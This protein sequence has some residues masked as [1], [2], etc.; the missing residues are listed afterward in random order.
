MVTPEEAQRLSAINQQSAN[1]PGSVLVQATK[2]QADNSFVDSLTDFFS[3]AKEKTYGAL[4]NAVFEQFNVNPDTGGFSELA[5]K[6]GLLGVRALYENVV[7][8]PIRTIGLVQQ[9]STWSEAYKKAQIEPF[10]YW[11]EAK[12]KGQKVDLGNALFQST[13]P[14]KTQTY[15]DLIDKGADPIKAR[16]IAISRLGVNVFDKVFEQEK[17]AQFDGDRAAALIARGKSPHMTPGRVLFKP[18]EFIAGPEDRAYDFYTGLIDLGLNLLDPTFWAGKAVKTVKAGRSMLTLTDEGADTFGLFKNGFVRKS[19][20]KT[21]AEQFLNSKQGDILAKFLYDN[22]DKP[23]EIL[24]KSNFKLVNQFVI[25]DQALSDEF[26]KFT[27]SLFSLPDNLPEQEAIA[28]IKNIWNE[29]IL[30]TATS[31]VVPVAPGMS[32]TARVAPDFLV[33]KVGTVRRAIDDYFGP[34]YETKLSANN[35]DK[36]I[37]EYTKFLKLLDPKDQLANRSQRVKNLITEITKKEVSNPAIRGKFIINQVMEDFSDLQKLYVK[38]LEDT[39]KLTT[40]TKELIRNVFST[41]GGILEEQSQL[42][43]F[44]PVLNNFKG[45]EDQISYLFKK[46]DL[47]K[48][49]TESQLDELGTNFGSRPVLE[50]M[51][52]QDLKLQNPSKVIKLTKTLDS[53]FNGNFQEA[54]RIIG[55]EGINRFFDFY[56][57]QIFKPIVLLRPAW[58]VRVIIEEQLRAVANGALGV[59]DHPIGLLARIFDDNIKVRGSYAKEGWLDTANFKLGISE[60]ASGQIGK[61]V[62]QNQKIKLSNQLKFDEA[63]RTQKPKEWADGQ[64]R[65]INLLRTD[66]ISKKIAAIEL[67]DNPSKG[68]AELAKALKTPGNQYREA[69]INLT[70]GRTNILKVLDGTAGLTPKEYDDAI[71]WFILGMRNN[72]K[73]FLSTDGKTVNPDLYNIVIKGT[74]TNAKG[75]TLSLDTARNIGVKQTDLDLLGKNALDKKQSIDIQRKATEY[76]KKVLKEYIDKFGGVLPEKVDYKVPDLDVPAGFYDIFVEKAFQFFMTTPTNKMSRIP[77]F[78][79]SYWKKSEELISISSENV[80]QK[81]IAGANKAGLNKK[82]I[83]RMEDTTS[84]GIK[85]IDDP[86]LIEVMAKG[87]GVEQTKKLLYDITQQRRFWEASRW[88]FPF[89]NAYQEVLTTWVGIMK[90]NPNVI[91]RTGT[92]WDGA[93][94]ENDTF[95]PSGKGIF[96]KNPINGQVVF[97]YPGTG[98]LQDWMFKDSA[99]NTDVRINMPVYAESINIA[100]GLLPGFGPVI[101]IPAAFIFKNFPEE[102]FVN[103]VLFGEFPP[104]DVNNKDEWTKALGL[105]PAWAD[106]FIQLIFNKGENAQGAFGNTVIDVYK[107]LLYSGQIDD[108]TEEKAKIGMQKAVETAQQVFLF[109]AVSQFLGPA[110]AASPIFEITDKNANYFMFETLADEYRKIKESVNYDDALA[111]Q[112]FIE[113]FGINPLPLT[114]AK[115]VTIEKRPT[116]VDGADWMKKNMDLYDQY[117]LV[118]W[119]LEPP[120]SYAEFSFDAYRKSLLEGTREYRTPEQFQ[121]AKNKLLGSVALEQYERE[122]G[123]IGNNTAAAKALRDAKKK[124]LEQRYWGYGQPGIAGSPV[125]PSI[126]TQIDQLIKMTQDPELQNFATIQAAQ[127]Y[128]VIRQQI[129]DTLVAAGKSETIW[130]TSKDYAGVRAALRNEATKL[131]QETPSFGPMFDTL[132]SRELEPEYEDNLLVQLGLGK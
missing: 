72:L 90:N 99:P 83:K 111:T 128:L 50:S 58:T 82:I 105:K 123:I 87:Y 54:K 34:L 43:K 25:N 132:L 113:Q 91:A 23:D 38:E 101:Q 47:A 79:S 95:G 35:P 70:Q 88:V 117:P 42:N 122:I 55:D 41:T 74:F 36:L 129:I 59:L 110:G 1:I 39:G 45:A 89:G 27:T 7:A 12:E 67:S 66:T 20:S 100:A 121:V 75:E 10:A 78:K 119:Y 5:L 94:Q 116:T 56:V 81:I 57:G 2:A 64:W 26:A 60:S 17:V 14:E 28:A 6:G 53:K 97:N 131:I 112:M 77:V 130:K 40:S 73:G 8:E 71:E 124:E 30:A 3:K 31:G 49:L 11:K 33:Q 84:A 107:A 85:G 102:G 46:S 9:G 68:F 18:L 92:I 13:D 48:D 51:L 65:M 32:R 29:K 15:R 61:Q 69:M 103:K 104:L 125:Q 93:A 19:F 16:E 115:T 96:Y 24:L 106:K 44:L 52:T 120:P 62:T 126:D 80:K 4:K 109:R 98:L 76:E 108:S 22:K 37:V 127:K 86:E 118:A 114:V 63:S 21:S